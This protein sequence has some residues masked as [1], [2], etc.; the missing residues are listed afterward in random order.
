MK[1]SEK[2]SIQKVQEQEKVSLDASSKVLSDAP[3]LDLID[4]EKQYRL[5][6]MN[7]TDEKQVQEPLKS[8][9]LSETKVN[10]VDDEYSDKKQPSLKEIPD[11]TPS[12]DK[13]LSKTR[14]KKKC[15]KKHSEKQETPE[16]KRILTRIRMKKYENDKKKSESTEVDKNDRSQNDKN[17]EFKVKEEIKSQDKSIK[18]TVNVKDLKSIFEKEKPP[19]TENSRISDKNLGA[20]P[21]LR[22]KT[23]PP[24][25]D[26]SQADRYCGD[27]VHESTSPVNAF[28][29]MKKNS[30]KLSM[31][32][33]KKVKSSKKV[34]KYT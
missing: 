3:S 34:L 18:E 25:Y 32:S 33:N 6:E 30:E 7:L 29:V 5:P 31:P 1:N 2:L 17:N 22:L 9:D 23:A 28:E 11:K 10:K 8:I 27:K 26:P 19:N 13:Y 12:Q 14:P 21:K 16:L 4:S 20:R 15:N 24:E